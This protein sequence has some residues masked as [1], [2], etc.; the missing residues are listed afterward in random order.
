[1]KLS[2]DDIQKTICLRK[3]AFQVVVHT[4]DASFLLHCFS[5]RAAFSL[6]KQLIR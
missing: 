2:S 3:A 6:L 4:F 5:L 1:M